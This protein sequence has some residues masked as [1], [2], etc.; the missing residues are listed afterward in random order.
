M[1]ATKAEAEARRQRDET[2]LAR[3][4]ETEHREI[5]ET[6]QR[7][8]EAATQAERK[9]KEAEAAQRRLVEELSAHLL[10]VFAKLS[11]LA[12]A[13]A[14]IDKDVIGPT[15]GHHQ[16]LDPVVIEVADPWV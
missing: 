14:E 11:K 15:V 6:N 8:A 1:R 16:V 12:I 10:D 2:E 3:Q 7:K 5:A 9:A 13:L 4:A